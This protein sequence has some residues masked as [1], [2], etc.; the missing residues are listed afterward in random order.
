[1]ALPCACSATVQDITARKRAE[2][3]VRQSEERL[4]L[5]QKVGRSGTWETILGTGQVISSPELQEVFGLD[6][7][8]AST[9]ASLW[10]NLIHPD[11]LANV[12]QALA[13]A[14]SSKTEF[15]AEFRINRPGGAERWI[16][17]TAQIFQDD[18]GKPTHVIGISTDIT[19]RKR[20][21]ETLKQHRER[22]D[23][24]T[25]AAH[26][27]FWFCDLPFDKLMWDD[28]VKEHFWLPADADVT[29]DMFYERLHPDDRERTRQAIAES[30]ASD[31]PYDIEYRTVSTDGREKWIRALGR[32]F[33]DDA[34][35][36]KS[37]DGLTLD[38]TAQKKVEERERQ[39]TAEAVAATAKFQA[40]FEQTTVFAGIMS[41]DGVI[42]EANRMCLDACGYRAEDVV[43][44]HFWD[45]PWWRNSPE[46]QQKIRA[47]TPL[48]AQG[49][50][51]RENLL[52]SWADGS[53]HLV[54][55][56]LYPIRDREGNILF[57]HPTGIDI[58]EIKQAEETYRNL[59]ETLDAEVRVRT[60]EV[61]QQS[62]QLRDLSSRLLQAQD[63][64]RRHIARELHDSAG[65]ILT[66]LGMTLAQAVRNSPH[67]DPR[68]AKGVQESQQLVQ[69]LSQEIRTMSYLL[70]PPLLDETGLSEALRWYIQGLSERSGLEIALEVA[71]DFE[72]LSREMELVMFRLVQECLTNMHRHSGS[73]SGVIRISRD[74]DSVSLEVQ[75]K[76]KGISA[77]KLSQIQ[78]Q[79]S[80]VGIRGMRERARHFGGHM[81]IESNHK[82]TKIAFKFPLPKN[83]VSGRNDVAQK[84]DTPQPA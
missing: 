62:E 49:T 74:H 5:A 36:P 57:L 84:E 10:R 2:E 31:A 14:I 39:M 37:F 48:A 41:V 72:R 54:D 6:S 76:G 27:G 58:T 66:A 78:S 20:A 34:G 79:G 32:T 83:T 17:T 59:A 44:K 81:L 9:D 68:L 30:N 21:E 26:V 15:R 23:L 63:E 82:G 42:M 11:D 12:D 35:R 38:I 60:S 13:L 24:V 56:A 22:F 19:E 3:S 77:E 70:H 51:F 61:V 43:G 4:R 47:A 73:K 80:G 53:E 16:E 71:P 67:A 52:Y 18:N 7:S 55:F 75:D 40:V 45:C 50:P 69:Q 28:L 64:E 1:M 25:E 65:Q 46:A 8:T 29:I 33:Y